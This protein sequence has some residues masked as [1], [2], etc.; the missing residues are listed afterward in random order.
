M[1][2]NYGLGQVGSGV[3]NFVSSL[4]ANDIFK[5][6]QRF[7]SGLLSGL[8]KNFTDL[9]FK[10]LWSNAIYQLKLSPVR[11]GLNSLQILGVGIST[12]GLIQPYFNPTFSIN[13][14]QTICAI[15]GLKAL[16]V[17]GAAGLVGAYTYTQV[18]G[19]ANPLSPYA[20]GAGAAA[21]GFIADKALSWVERQIYNWAGW[22]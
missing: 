1:G 9:A 10:D 12:L 16:I 2:V 13:K 8:N 21:A 22:N 18:G 14:A 7:T 15:R 4:P 17:T 6:T 19:L 5:S 3:S 11:T 20:Y